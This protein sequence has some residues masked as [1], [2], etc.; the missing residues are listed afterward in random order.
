MNGQC[1]GPG[2]DEVAARPACAAAAVNLRCSHPEVRFEQDFTFCQRLLGFQSR[3][4]DDCFDLAVLIQQE[5]RQ[6]RAA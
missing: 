3:S 2:F 6:L 5:I 1:L 4:L